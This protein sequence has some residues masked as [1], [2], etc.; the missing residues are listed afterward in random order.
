[1]NITI[2]T[3]DTR[4]AAVVS[5]LGFPI[6]LDVIYNDHTGGSEITYHIDIKSVLPEIATTSNDLIDKIKQKSL[7]PLHPCQEGLRA[8]HNRRCLIKLIKSNE[9]IDL[10]PAANNQRYIYIHRGSGIPGL[11]TN[12]EVIATEDIKVVAAMA[13]LGVP[14]LSLTESGDQKKFYMPVHGLDLKGE[15]INAAELLRDFR[16]GS[17]AVREPEHPFL[18]SMMAQHTYVEI[19]KAVEQKEELILLRKRN[20]TKAAYIRASASD[21]AFDRV[22][23]HFS[24]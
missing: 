12:T 21:K 22:Y 24:L 2:P 1:M 11:S 9:P 13:N 14:L 4:I 6:K 19:L 5:M 17:L 16:D 7:P 18:Y 10:V 23:R 15:R 3:S 20:S 8:L